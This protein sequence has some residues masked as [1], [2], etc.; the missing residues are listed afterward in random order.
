MYFLCNCLSQLW[1]LSHMHKER[2][3]LCTGCNVLCFSVHIFNYFRK[4]CLDMCCLVQDS[5]RPL[6]TAKTYRNIG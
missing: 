5:I 4:K 2:I 3:L 6:L 1:N